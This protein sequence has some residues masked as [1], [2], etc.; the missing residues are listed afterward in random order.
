VWNSTAYGVDRTSGPALS[1]V[2][3][4]TGQGTSI[5]VSLSDTFANGATTTGLT[6]GSKYD[7]DIAS[8]SWYTGSW[9]NNTLAQSEVG[10]ISLEGLTPGGRY[11]ISLFAS[12]TDDD[13]GRGRITRYT[14]GSEYRDLDIVNNT[15]TSALFESIF[16][17]ENGL[18]DITVSAAAGTTSRFGFISAMEITALAPIPEPIT[19]ALL[20]AGA[21][22]MAVRRRRA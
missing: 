14:I 2:K 10:V 15:D 1:F 9:T 19:L 3:T 22:V 21:A 13:G 8:D 16:A 5:I 12:H 6:S 18:L 11:M 17:D 4:T 7:A 20:G